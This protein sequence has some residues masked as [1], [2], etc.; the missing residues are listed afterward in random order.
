MTPFEEQ[1]AILKSECPE[2]FQRKF[3]SGAYL[4]TVPSVKL[5]PGWSRDKID[6]KFI[7]PVGFPYAKPDCFWAEPTLRLKN[8]GIP[9]NAQL[10]AIPE[11]LDLPPHLWFSWHLGQWNPSQDN[12][13]TFFHVIQTRLKDSQ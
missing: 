6:I 3:P 1:F 9:K 13:S 2:V 8:G 7:A 12:L 4:I 10:Q 5:S 11:A